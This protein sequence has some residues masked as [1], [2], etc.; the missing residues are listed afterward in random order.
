MMKKFLV[1]GSSGYLGSR[2]FLELD[3]GFGTYSNKNFGPKSR[4]FHLDISESGDLESLLILLKPDVVL[5]CIGFTNVDSCENQPEKNYMLNSWV[6]FQLASLCKELSIKFVHFSTD[7]FTNSA[8]EKLMESDAISTINQYSFAKFLAERMI[9]QVNNSAIIIRANFFHFNFHSPRSFLDILINTASK[10]DAVESFNDIY[11][12][13]VSTSYL[14]RCMKILLDLNFAGLVQIASNEVVSKFEFHE[15]VLKELGLN[16]I[17]HNPISVDKKNLIARRPKFMALD[18][19][20]L[21]KITGTRAPNLYDMIGEEIIH[22]R[23][24][25]EFQSAKR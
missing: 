8:E 19:A 10:V 3:N 21:T 18:N 4:M 11:F 22:S 7:H 25:E 24:L 12:T 6:P 1:L 2:L 23:A 17:S 9:V 16:T 20:L 13:P 5:N 15:M 14:I